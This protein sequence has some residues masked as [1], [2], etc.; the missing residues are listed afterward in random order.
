MHYHAVAHDH[1]TRAEGQPLAAIITHVYG[2]RTVNLVVFNSI[3]APHSR[4]YVQLMQPEDDIP[5]PRYS[6]CR[7]MEYQIGQAAKTEELQRQLQGE[8]SE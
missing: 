3:G 4:T 7:W 1:I 6:Y 5:D 8:K 2:D